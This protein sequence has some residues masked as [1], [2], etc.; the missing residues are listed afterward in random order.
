[1]WILEGLMLLRNQNKIYTCHSYSPTAF[2]FIRPN[3]ELNPEADIQL[4]EFELPSV[5][6]WRVAVASPPQRHSIK[7]NIAF[8]FNLPAIAELLNLFSILRK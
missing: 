6:T 3:K 4:Y 2:D 1:M 7:P 5:R 8:G